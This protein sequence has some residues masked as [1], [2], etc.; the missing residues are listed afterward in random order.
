MII[1]K[2]DFLFRNKETTDSKIDAEEEESQ[3]AIGKEERQKTKER[4]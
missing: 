2:L 4:V 1:I 3:K